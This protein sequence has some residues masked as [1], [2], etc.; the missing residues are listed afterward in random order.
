MLSRRHKT[1]DMRHIHHKIRAYFIGYL[2]ETLEVYRPGICACARKNELGLAFFGKA[3]HLIVIY[4]A[5]F[6]IH[7]V[8]HDIEI[9]TRY[10]YGRAVA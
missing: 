7:A 3:L 4:R 10:V 8:R 9:F 6:F 2:P 1:C 5:G